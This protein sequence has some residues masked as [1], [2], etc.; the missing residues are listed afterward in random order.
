MF[1]PRPIVGIGVFSI[2]LCVYLFVILIPYFRGND[3]NP[4]Q[5]VLNDTFGRIEEYLIENNA[6][7]TNT[8]DD[9]KDQAIKLYLASIRTYFP[10][11]DPK[12]IGAPKRKQFILY[13]DL[14]FEARVS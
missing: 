3:F 5:D 1:S 13:F 14:T 10:G 11:K 6:T 9:E 2:F 7:Y 8:T 12:I 4:L